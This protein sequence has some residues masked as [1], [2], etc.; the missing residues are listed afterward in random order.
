MATLRLH[1]VDVSVGAAARERGRLGVSALVLLGVALGFLVA[2]VATAIANPSG[3]LPI[4]GVDY[5]IYM[6]A[7]R[8]WLNGG[9]FY[10]PL[11]L[12]GPYPV[13][14]GDILY[15][16]NALIL[17]APFTILPA[18]LWWAIP[19]LTTA[20]IVWFWR[21]STLAL[22]AIVLCLTVPSTWWRIEAGN[23]VLWIVAA[24]ALGTRYRWPAVAVM[25]KPSLLPFAF[26][27][28]RSRSWWLALAVAALISLAFLPMWLDYVRVLLNARG[29][30]ASLLYS[31][32]DVPLL[33]IPLVAWL[34]RHR[35]AQ[36]I[37]HSPL[38]AG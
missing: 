36:A 17:F 38:H 26:V 15:P 37:D 27:G 24:L 34:G 6:E 23:P 32:G 16:P 25:I 21:P 11:Q 2:E 7:T 19:I 20:W 3:V 14:L 18:V 4:L 10:L 30:P 35:D 22:A 12:A 1:R 9:S 28:I 33:A 13:L 8:S 31:A 5:R 29:E